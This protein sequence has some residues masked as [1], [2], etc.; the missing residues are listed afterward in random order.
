MGKQLPVRRNPPP[1]CTSYWDLDLW[2]CFNLLFSSFVLP[3][4]ANSVGPYNI[5]LQ[6]SAPQVE[7]AITTFVVCQQTSA[8]HYIAK[9]DKWVNN[10]IE[11]KYIKCTKKGWS[12]TQ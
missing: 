4:I 7:S 6:I 1:T 10:T 12:S 5:A 2:M 11:L 3:I 8:L 9:C